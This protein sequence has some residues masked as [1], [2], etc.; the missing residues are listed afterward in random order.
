MKGRLIIPYDFDVEEEEEN[1]N[2]FFP[3]ELKEVLE[4][5]FVEVE[6]YG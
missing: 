1:I 4:G 5:S 2:I 3:E 6:F